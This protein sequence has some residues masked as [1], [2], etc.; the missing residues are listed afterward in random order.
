MKPNAWLRLLPLA[1]SLPVAAFPA[2]SVSEK[3][4][5]EQLLVRGGVPPGVD[6]AFFNARD[7]ILA[8]VES[9][10]ALLGVAGPVFDRHAAVLRQVE[11]AA[12]MAGT[13]PDIAKVRSMLDAA[14]EGAMRDLVPGSNDLSAAQID[15][16]AALMGKKEMILSSLQRG[17]IRLGAG[18]R[19][20][21]DWIREKV[22]MT[23]D[24][25]AL[26]ALYD[27]LRGGR[28]DDI[29][30][31]DAEAIGDIQR[32]LEGKAAP[33]NQLPAGLA[34]HASIDIPSPDTELPGDLPL[35]D[36]AAALNPADE[37]SVYRYAK[38]YG[39][40]PGIVLTA[41]RE[42]KRRGID[43]RMALAVIQAESSFDPGATSH[44][45]AR[46]LMQVMPDTG[47]M[48][49]VRDKADLYKPS[50]NIWAGVK[51]LKGLF[52]QFVDAS[53]SQIMTLSPSVLAQ[54]QLA[55]ASYNAGPDAIK[56]YGNKV[57]PYRETREYVVRVLS[58]YRKFCKK[59]PA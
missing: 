8:E 59:F 32:R 6:P 26:A 40:D 52:D 4:P 2:G 46:G 56:K 23:D 36:P 5:A 51:Y 42:S 30:I 1:A 57:P 27:R 22:L 16:Q 58:N 44:C 38:A 54:V 47:R 13:K 17:R 10:K 15:A 28:S 53:W 11:S 3:T 19:D 35:P 29:P 14:R 37:Y 33:G 24:P 20:R 18:E 45:G 55:V 48:L 43:Y 49:G 31:A 41:F 12:L 25:A 34:P 21:I 9:L 50:V 39:Y 7:V